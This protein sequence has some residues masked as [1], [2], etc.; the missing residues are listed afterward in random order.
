[1]CNWFTSYTLLEF[2]S[3]RPCSNP[4]SIILALACLVL[5]PAQ[6]HHPVLQCQE[7]KVFKWRL[8]P[9]LKTAITLTPML[10]CLTLRQKYC[11]IE[12]KALHFLLIIP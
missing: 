7:V 8:D 12:E 10:N 9:A 6:H 2:T 1:M 11:T 4:E 5:V 3:F